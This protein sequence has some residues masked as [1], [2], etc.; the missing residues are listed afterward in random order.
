MVNI[1]QRERILK[2]RIKRAKRQ[3][4]MI[5]QLG[6]R[7]DPMLIGSR[8]TM[9]RKKDQVRSRVASARKRE[10]GLFVS[11]EQ[12]VEIDGTPQMIS[13]D[14]DTVEPETADY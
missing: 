1:K 9:A 7:V 12:C 6:M 14:Y 5:N 4:Q 10:K 13:D 8:E 2:Q 11:K 3:L